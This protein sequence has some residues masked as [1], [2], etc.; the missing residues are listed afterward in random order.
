MTAD[1]EEIEQAQEEGIQ[2]HPAQSFEKILKGNDNKVTGVAF[3]DILS[4]T[5]D[6]NRRAIIE[7]AERLLS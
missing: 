6:E 3:S 7:K 4:F 5:F 2:V 1:E